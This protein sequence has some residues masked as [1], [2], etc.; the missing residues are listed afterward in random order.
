MASYYYLVSSLP[1][2]RL[3]DGPPLSDSD[4]LEACRTIVSAR[5]MELIQA[6]TLDRSELGIHNRFLDSWISYLKSFHYELDEQRA[7]KLSLDQQ[8]FRN[9]EGRDP[10]ISDAV[11][12]IMAAS[13][14]LQAELLMLHSHW[15]RIEMLV[16]L[17]AFD[18]EVLMAWRLKA[19]ISARGALF[20]PLEGNAEFKRLFS[21][22][23]TTIKSI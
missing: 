7:R 22:L 12:T 23:Q 10:W 5:D 8:R 15:N 1:M 11:R 6:S 16:G 21:N 3:G 14:P 20:V 13:D 2:V 19:L 17:H 18:V 4:F 9:P